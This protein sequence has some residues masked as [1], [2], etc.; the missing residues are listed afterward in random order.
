MTKSMD[1]NPD[2]ISIENG[3]LRHIV[4]LDC[5]NSIQVN[6]INGE[7]RSA[8]I[9]MS[10]A[11]NNINVIG[12]RSVE[13]LIKFLEPY[14]ASEIHSKATGVSSQEPELLCL[15]ENTHGLSIGLYR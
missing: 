13:Q 10:D 12:S 7:F 2:F 15:N 14:V 11:K 5:I 8:V 9:T 1:S 4:N 3:E 6:C